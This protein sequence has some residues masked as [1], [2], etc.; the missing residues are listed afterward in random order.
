VNDGVGILGGTF[1]PIHYGH[2]RV[3]AEVRS[4]LGLAE[5]RLIPAGN[6][7]HRAGVIAGPEDRLAM[8]RLA[9]AEFPGL[10]V[11][12]REV[13]K[14]G[15]SYTVET[16]TELR[17]E[18]GPRPLLLLLGA[19]AFL[20][21]PTWRRWTELFELAHVVVIARPG[22]ALPEAMPGPLA[23]A[24][25]RRR[26]ADPALLSA[27]AGRI[28]V[29]PVTPQPISATAIRALFGAG[30]R[31]EGLLPPAVVAYIESRSLYKS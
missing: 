21:L 24:W 9:V 12:P 10:A 18:L 22:H 13:R 19:D 20:S 28:Y 6:P 7:Y 29:Q 23:A 17:A 8:A 14:A 16:L 11:D 3:A 31:P 5:V 26:T 4:A 30:G 1:D 15:P 2:L 27:P 25:T